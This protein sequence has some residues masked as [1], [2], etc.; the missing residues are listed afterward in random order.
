MCAAGQAVSVWSVHHWTA[1][2]S[3]CLWDPQEIVRGRRET[4]KRSEVD[5]H[6]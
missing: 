3:G 5:M 2:A 6:G 1:H 4:A